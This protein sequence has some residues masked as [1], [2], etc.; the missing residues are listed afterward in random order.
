MPPVLFSPPMLKFNLL[1]S[2]M[3]LEAPRQEPLQP[4]WKD[5][6]PPLPIAPLAL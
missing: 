6:E 2:L 1:R 3:I 5:G 4:A